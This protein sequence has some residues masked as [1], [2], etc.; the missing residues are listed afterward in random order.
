MLFRILTCLLVI[1]AFCIGKL[2]ADAPLF[3]KHEVLEMTIPVDFK[4]LCRPRETPDCDYTPTVL[5]YVDEHGKMQSLEIEI[6]IR[7]GWRSL[8]R[9]CSAPLLFIRFHEEQT[10]DTPFEGQ[11]VLPLTTHCGQGLSLEAAQTRQH[12][13]TWEQYLIKEY[14]AHRFY[15]LITPVSI[16]A[17]LARMTYPNPEKPSRRIVNYAFFT[18]HFK[19]V[20]ARN[21][22]EVLKRHSFDHEKLDAHASGLLALFQYMVGNTDWSITRERNVV[23]LLDPEGSQLPLPYDFDMSGLVNA[24]Y[25]GPAPGLPIDEV[26][27]RYYLGFCQ[28]GTDW[29]SLFETYLEEETALVNMVKSLPELDK[30]NR[31]S[32]NRFMKGFFA[33]LRSPELRQKAIVDHCQTWPPSSIDHLTPSEMR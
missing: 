31:K 7:G 18:E 5:E 2:R 9:N 10:L 1:A 13:S 25:A 14:L 30:Q 12:R 28:P 32:V 8:T 29:D 24:H 27:E 22:A 23:L 19:S 33:T 15:N 6:I 26:R 17:R 21:D 20:A 4:T 3:S 11:T 16:K